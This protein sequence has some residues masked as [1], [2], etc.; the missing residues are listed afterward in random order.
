MVQTIVQKLGY[1]EEEVRNYV[2]KDKTSFVGVLYQKLVDDQHDRKVL[3]ERQNQIVQ[4]QLQLQQNLSQNT[5]SEHNISAKLPIHP[6]YVPSLGCLSSLNNQN[7]NVST[8]KVSLN[9]T[10]SNLNLN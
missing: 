7:M 8:S 9:Q 1:T 10:S 4:K 3:M 5:G 6:S 2:T